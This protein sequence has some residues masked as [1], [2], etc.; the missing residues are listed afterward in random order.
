[1]KI[2]KVYNTDFFGK[3][4]RKKTEADLFASGYR[5]ESE[6]ET[7]EWDSGQ[8]CCLLILFFPLVFFAHLK[9]V[10]VTYT[11]DDKN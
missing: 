10:K 1:M 4:K 8:A 3:L 7:K 9:K 5:I 11:S 6:E 2:I